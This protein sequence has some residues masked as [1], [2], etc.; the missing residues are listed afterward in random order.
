MNNF[1]RG[2]GCAV[3]TIIL[4]SIPIL[5]GVCWALNVPPYIC[6]ILSLLTLGEAIVLGMVI[7]YDTEK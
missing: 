7:Y 4:L 1:L 3:V 5:T 2:I 6:F